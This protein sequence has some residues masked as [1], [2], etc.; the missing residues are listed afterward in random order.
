MG[1]GS[2]NEISINFGTNF[3]CGRVE[4]YLRGNSKSYVR[5]HKI[6]SEEMGLSQVIYLMPT[7]LYS[8]RI[9][10]VGFRSGEQSGA[11]IRLL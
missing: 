8:V 11:E 10:A 6:A 3:R 5:N 1:F 4:L 9:A 7:T 2:T